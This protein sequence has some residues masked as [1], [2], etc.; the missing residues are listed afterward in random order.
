MIIIRSDYKP[1][2]WLIYEEIRK[3]RY[4]RQKM[5]AGEEVLKNTFLFSNMHRAARPN[6]DNMP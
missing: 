6:F 4:S 1:I 2:Y 3:D 5:G